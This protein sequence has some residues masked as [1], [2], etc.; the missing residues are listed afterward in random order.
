MLHSILKKNSLIASGKELPCAPGAGTIYFTLECYEDKE[1]M[2]ILSE[3]YE[4]GFSKIG[5]RINDSCFKV[6]KCG[7][8]IVYK[9]DAEDFNQ[10]MA[11]RGNNG[12][13]P[14]EGFDILQNNFAISTVIVEGYK[15]M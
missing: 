5:I 7:L 9:K 14:H 8:C 11:Q 1:N 12:F 10:F 6:K 13:T 4:K 2:Y 15:A 3:C